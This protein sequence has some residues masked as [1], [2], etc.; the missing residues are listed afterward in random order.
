MLHLNP[1]RLGRWTAVMSLA[2][3]ALGCP[4]PDDLLTDSDTASDSRADTVTGTAQNGTESSS[5]TDPDGTDESTETSETQSGPSIPLST[6]EPACENNGWQTVYP[7]RGTSGIMALAKVTSRI[8]AVGRQDASVSFVDIQTGGWQTLPPLTNVP[9]S[10]SARSMS[11][12]Y[13]NT[14]TGVKHFDGTSWND[15][16]YPEGTTLSYDNIF[17][18]GERLYAAGKDRGVYAYEQG[19]WSLVTRR[20]KHC[21]AIVNGSLCDSGI[22][23]AGGTAQD[24]IY[25]SQYCYCIKDTYTMSRVLHWNGKTW[26]V[27]DSDPYDLRLAVAK[28]REAWG[29]SSYG[30]DATVLRHYVGSRKFNGPSLSASNYAQIAA[31]EQGFIFVTVHDPWRGV[32]ARIWSQG[33]WHEDDRGVGS[34]PT[35]VLAMGKGAFVVGEEMGRLSLVSVGSKS[36]SLSWHHLNSPASDLWL[37]A[38]P[39]IHNE[40]LF[41]GKDGGLLRGSGTNFAAAKLDPGARPTC[42]ERT[43]KGL[44]VIGGAYGTWEG[45]MP[46]A[47]GLWCSAS[48]DG[49]VAV[50]FDPVPGDATQRASWRKEPC[51][52]VADLA[53]APDADRVYALC[54]NGWLL[55]LEG[56]HIAAI[57]RLA[58][59]SIVP[60]LVA[61]ADGELWIADHYDVW[62]RSSS[63]WERA[64]SVQND[65]WVDAWRAP[66]TSEI[67]FID[68]RGNLFW[69]TD[70]GLELERLVPVSSVLSIGGFGR[71][72]FYIVGREYLAH[73]NGAKW[74]WSSMKAFPGQRALAGPSSND[75][76]MASE[77]GT[78]GRKCGKLF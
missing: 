33:V 73:Y 27:V 29:L 1:L 36:G 17:G 15:I 21:P 6:D 43:T 71:N 58:L 12:L 35:A 52:V 37:G 63:L 34:L 28:Q 19:R 51:D 46:S 10:L 74:K 49:F 77:D 16:A 68:I 2:A 76:Y 72:D 41:V 13:A 31:D 75:F 42:L 25:V 45:D 26:T 38:L 53:A 30:A 78:V 70:S 20:V 56:C 69:W 11:D 44:V 60:D 32:V 40:M 65:Y 4:R 64:M 24:D 3:V 5:A 50:D 14:A 59:E 39:T 23:V 48:G 9:Y 18:I 7:K 55:E 54:R 62:H 47:P 22:A 67:A 57:E 61:R 66:D 8:I